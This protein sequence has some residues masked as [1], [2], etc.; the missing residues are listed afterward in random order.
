MCI[1]SIVTIYTLDLIETFCIVNQVKV[2]SKN[3]LLTYL[4]ETFCIVNQVKVLSKNILLT[5]LIE[6]FC[7]VNISKKILRC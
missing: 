4:I 3:I 6:T 7:I 1:R 5:Y 2:L